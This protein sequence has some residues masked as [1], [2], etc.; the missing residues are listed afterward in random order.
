M[1]IRQT[2]SQL[3]LTPMEDDLPDILSYVLYD[4][5]R[6]YFLREFVRKFKHSV[7]K[8]TLKESAKLITN[9]SPHM[10]DIV[11]PSILDALFE[12]KDFEINV[13]GL[14]NYEFIVR[15]GHPKII[16]N[17]TLPRHMD[18][19]EL[20]TYF[21]ISNSE[22]LLTLV[23]SFP[24]SLEQR[25]IQDIPKLKLIPSIYLY[26]K[27]KDLFKNIDYKAFLKPLERTEQTI[28]Y[29]MMFVDFMEPADPD[30][31]VDTKDDDDFTW[32][33]YTDVE[34]EDY[35]TRLL[36]FQ[37]LN[38]EWNSEFLDYLKEHRLFNFLYTR[39]INDLK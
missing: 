13:F 11:N 10:K 22:A 3:T 29:S 1:S 9:V 23:K 16:S 31:S 4:E 7:S 2:W 30:D 26:I 14:K 28:D 17:P 32:F 6:M 34:S 33:S 19:Q 15:K 38:S 18:I 12:I 24:A 25:F 39:V 20:Y 21:K 35:R 36:I 27:E 37:Y 8:D 5:S